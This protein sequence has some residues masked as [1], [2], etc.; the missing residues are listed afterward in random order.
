MPGTCFWVPPALGSLEAL[1][2][3]HRGVNSWRFRGAAGTAVKGGRAVGARPRGGRTRGPRCSGPGSV[4]SF[5]TLLPWS[6]PGVPPRAQ[7]GCHCHSAAVPRT[8]PCPALGCRSWGECRGAAA[9]GWQLLL[10]AASPVPGVAVP[11]APEQGLG[12]ARS[13]RQARGCAH[14]GC[15]PRASASQAPC[16][17]LFPHARGLERD[18]RISISLFIRGVNIPV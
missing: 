11:S 13:L 2:A 10:A 1:G 8:C 6:P 15:A 18:A 5:P 9:P 12:R 16:P 14:W 4:L 17:V 7:G 3:S